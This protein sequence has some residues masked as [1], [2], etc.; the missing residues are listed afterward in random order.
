MTLVTSG[1][2]ISYVL[3]SN[4]TPFIPGNHTETIS[5]EEIDLGNGQIILF[6]SGLSTSTTGQIFESSSL[7]IIFRV[8]GKEPYGAGSYD[9]GNI[10]PPGLTYSDVEAALDKYNSYTE[11]DGV[12]AKTFDIVVVPEPTSLAMLGLGGLLIKRRRREKVTSC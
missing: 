8:N 12:P 10:L 2:M 7:D 3:E 9:I 4:G 5:L 6:K 11:D 1:P